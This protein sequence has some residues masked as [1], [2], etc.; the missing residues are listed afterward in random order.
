KDINPGPQASLPTNFFAVG[1]VAYFSAHTET[2]GRELWVTDGTA[3]GTHEVANLNPGSQPSDVGAV[4]VLGSV[5]FVIASPGSGYG[6]YRID[7]TAN[8]LIKLSDAGVP[9]NAQPRSLIVP[10]NGKAYYTGFSQPLGA[11]LW[12]TDGTVNGTH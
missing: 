1:S 5:V 9:P 6:L 10:G 8:G 2:D 4:G 7:G 3:D 12:V 11:E